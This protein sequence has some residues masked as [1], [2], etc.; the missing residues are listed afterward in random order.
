MFCFKCGNQ[1]PNDA[2]FCNKCGAQQNIKIENVSQQQL[3]NDFDKKAIEIY[4]SNL[5]TLECA[6]IKLKEEECKAEH[7]LYCENMNNYVQ[8]YPIL[9]GYVWLAYH[10]GIFHLGCFDSAGS[11]AYTGEYLNREEHADGRGFVKYVWG[12]E[13]IEHSGRFYWGIIN[14]NALKIMNKS[15]FWWD[16]GGNNT[17]QLMSRQ[18]KA[19]DAFLKY[20]SEFTRIAPLKWEENY[21]NI[22]KPLE[23]RFDG[24]KKEHMKIKGL[25]KDAYDIN[26]IPQ[27]FRNFEAVWYLK[28][29]ITSSN[30]TLTT[31][32][33]HC[34]IEKIKQK[35]D[36]IIEQQEEIIL[37]QAY[38]IA[39]NNQIISQNQ[40][41]LNNL[42]SIESNA[43]RAAQYTKIAANNT[44]VVAAIQMSEYLRP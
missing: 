41:M 40:N 38:Q 18:A 22:V 35:L 33:L 42:A 7:E 6:Q 23:I 37:N 14:D 13:I 9:D 28:D 11:G 43:E 1:I 30:E 39:Q 10:D 36:T 34:D 24:I 8:S 19:R 26:I 20:Y 29:F 44:G 32:L 25:L 15:S 17:L 27:Q 5:L 12:T 2:N 21:N 4:L 31:A 3:S 16:I